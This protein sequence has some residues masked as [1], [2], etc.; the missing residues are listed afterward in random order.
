MSQEIEFIKHLE[1]CTENVKNWP[2]WKRSIF[3]MTKLRVAKIKISYDFL[4]EII[5]FPET[6]TIE[7]VEDDI[8]ENPYE[9]GFLVYITDPEL[10][11]VNVMS[12]KDIPLI[13]P[14]VKKR[15]SHFLLKWDINMEERKEEN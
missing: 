4:R 15:K 9:N 3:G 7:V 10:P 13:T 2:E 8:M 1:K 12:K 5:P 14:V 6:T 11:E